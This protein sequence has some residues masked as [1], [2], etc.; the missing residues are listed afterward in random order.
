MLCI[1]W[2][3][4]PTTPSTH[5]HP[6]LH[7]PT[8]PQHTHTCST[9]HTQPT[10]TPFSTHPQGTLPDFCPPLYYHLVWRAVTTNPVVI[11]KPQPPE[12]YV[13]LGCLVS[14]VLSY[15]EAD[16]VLCVRADRVGRASMASTAVWSYNPQQ[17][18]LESAIPSMSHT[19]PHPHAYPPTRAHPHPHPHTHTTPSHTT[20]HPPPS[21]TTHSK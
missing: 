11:W 7:T 2:H 21:H 9:H 19:Q 5:P 18:L 10:H 13:A 17:F 20:P 6:I 3:P 1:I 14:S 12:G 8:H 15:P 16:A 4:I